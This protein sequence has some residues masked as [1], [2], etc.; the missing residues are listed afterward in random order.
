MKTCYTDNQW[1]G[2]N[3][4]Y[5]IREGYSWLRPHN[6]Q[7]N[8]APMVWNNWNFPKYSMIAW[9]VMNE[10]LKVEA[11]LLQFGTCPDD[12]CCNCDN[13]S[14]TQSHFFFECPYSRRVM[15]A[16]KQWC[17]FRI[18]VN[19]AGWL[20]HT[21]GT[22]LKKQVHFLIWTACYAHI[23]Y[24]RNNARLNATLVLPDKLAAIIKAEVQGRVRFNLRL[25]SPGVQDQLN[26]SE[27]TWL[28]KWGVVV[29]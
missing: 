5:A 12:R 28:Q 24:Q 26:G 13:A 21:A 14:E 15:N 16:V 29:R 27:V 25:L 1:S 19:M 23:W 17:G 3:K 10:G 4:P 22:S 8:W 6:H 11:K 20:S 7:A 2:T 9:I 18:N